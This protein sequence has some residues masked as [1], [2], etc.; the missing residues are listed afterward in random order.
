[1]LPVTKK[2]L[3]ICCETN[4]DSSRWETLQ[5]SPA[6]WVVLLCHLEPCWHIVSSLHKP[7]MG[8][9][10]LLCSQRQAGMPAMIFSALCSTG[11]RAGARRAGPSKAWHTTSLWGCS[12]PA[13]YGLSGHFP[14]SCENLE[15]FLVNDYLPT[16]TGSLLLSTNSRKECRECRRGC[17]RPGRTFPFGSGLPLGLLS[18]PGGPWMGGLRGSCGET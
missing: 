16:R 13:R 3:T 15:N 10:I 18:P 2:S 7:G 9:K 6:Q 5:T 4:G 12:A 17:H 14:L 8:L 1:M 11:L